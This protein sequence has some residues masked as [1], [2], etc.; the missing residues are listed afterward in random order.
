[1]AVQ[2]ANALAGEQTIEFEFPAATLGMMETITLS[3]GTEIVV[4][5]ALKIH[6]PGAGQ[7]TIDGGNGTNRIFSAGL[8]VS[9]ELTGITLTGGNGVGASSSGVGGAV[10]ARGDLTLEE[11]HFTANDAASCGGA[12]AISAGTHVIRNTTYSG[13][14]SAITGGGLCATTNS[15]LTI[16]NCTFSGNTAASG[17]GGI[18]HTGASLLITNSTIFANTGS[19]GGG[20]L[21]NTGSNVTVRSSI[22]AGNT[23][24]STPEISSN[25]AVI[26]Q[27][28]NLVGDDSGDSLNTGITYQPTDIVDIDPLLAPLANYGGPTPTHRPFQTSPIKDKGNS[29]GLMTEQR[30]FARIY[31]FLDP[32]NAGDGADIGAV[33]ILAPSA[34]AVSLSGR[35]FSGEGTAIRGVTVTIFGGSL[36]EPITVSTGTFGAF[37][38]TGL[39][40]GETYFVSVF[41]GRYAF[42][43]PVRTVTLYD[44]LSDF[45]FVAVPR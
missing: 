23:G 32:V 30:G 25:G 10:L 41:S 13:N 15:N 31:D 7:L 26:S 14:T 38:F 16:E 39:R 3:S 37:A 4:T 9:F 2:E 1:M 29:F 17:G 28:F 40:A 20:G 21:R 45:E 27:G 6:G 42:D 11:M 19:A 12:V 33:E 22:I 18:L 24:D 43:E 36:V 35:V 44:D 34:A 5:D 8:G